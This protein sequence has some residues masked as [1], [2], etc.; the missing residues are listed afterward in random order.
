MKLLILNYEY[1]PIGGGAGIITEYI[2]KGLSNKSHD[3]TVLTTW[4]TDKKDV[5][6]YENLRIIRLKSKRK[7]L[8][9]SNPWEMWSWVKMSKKFLK[10][11]L[12]KERYDLCIA[13]FAI[14]GG[15]VAYSFKHNYNLPYVIIS[16]GH[17]IPWFY[18][19][20]MFWYHLFTYH[21][22]R[23]ICLQSELN[24]VQ[25]DEMKNNIDAF[26]GL[27]HNN[28]N[29]II[30]N[31]WDRANFYPDYKKRN[32]FL[33]IVFPGRLV[34]QK[35]PITFLKSIT[36]ASKKIPNLQ[37]KI[38]G[39][40]PLMNEL[41]KYVNENE[42]NNII[43]FKG[44]LSKSEMLEEYQSSSLTVLPSI[45]EGM[46][47]SLMEALACGHYIITTDVSN[48]KTLISENINGNIIEKSNP[49]QIA[50]KIVYYYENKFKENYIISKNDLEKY[51]NIYSW[52]SII[53]KY[54]EEF[55]ELLEIQTN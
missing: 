21:W 31:G 9:K 22:I 50:D 20:Q 41:K 5:E 36:I 10:K 32:D 19:E 49:Q 15:E 55:L 14:P 54:E 17:D 28:K 38:L 26:L 27:K 45:N 29:K 47:I 37:V 34:K 30:H 18:P 2:A 25:S 23:R 7:T 6:F 12:L 40:G 35:D 53:N 43:T 1:P 39:N 3:V 48:N 11:H 52:D 46:S 24:F 44:W 33:T 13:N 4:F 8:Y 51:D 42:L 16:H